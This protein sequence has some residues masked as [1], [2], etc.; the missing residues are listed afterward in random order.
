MFNITFFC[1]R[2][3]LI[4]Y[5]IITAVF[6][7]INANSQN[8]T[9]EVMNNASVDL[10]ISY[11]DI[12]NFNNLMHDFD[13]KNY[14]VMF[15][16]LKNS[17][18][19][20]MMS[21]FIWKYLISNVSEKNVNSFLDFNLMANFIDKNQDWPSMNKA[22]R[23]FENILPNMNLDYVTLLEWFE[24]YPPVT[25][26]GKKLLINSY[27]KNN[28]FHQRQIHS[29]NQISDLVKET[30]VDANFNIDI[31]RQFYQQYKQYLINIF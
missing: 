28:E 1:I 7:I 21:Y 10:P 9:S 4:S 8:V 13:K 11:K 29:K 23:R 3:L 5:I 18:N 14:Q 2:F 25:G 30:W 6:P 24:K 27:V 15:S 12:K 16:K 17:D 22:V 20:L 19:N 31:E 26:V